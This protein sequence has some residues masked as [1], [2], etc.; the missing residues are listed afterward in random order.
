MGPGRGI[1][2]G[3]IRSGVLAIVAV[4]IAAPRLTAQDVHARVGAG[5]V[6]ARPLGALDQYLSSAYGAGAFVELGPADRVLVLKID[7]SFIRFAPTTSPRPFRGLQPVF[8]TTGSQIF[9]VIAGPEL[10][11][12]L[13]RVRLTATAGGGIASSTNT[14]AVAGIGTADRFSGATTFGD[15]TLA[16]AGGAGLGLEVGGGAAPVWLDLST[17]Y[18]GTGPTRWVREGN[19]PVGYVSGV[20]LKPTQSPTRLVAFQL[21]VSVG[22]PR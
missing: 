22:V 16:Y 7:A 3:M 19:L 1:S 6:V 11:V 5:P 2:S 4:A 13:G 15:L 20:Y 21:S 18:V 10:R 8:I 9:A 14:G 12:G 17:R